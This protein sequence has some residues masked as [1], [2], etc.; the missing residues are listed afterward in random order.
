LDSGQWKTP[1]NHIGF[2]V[3]IVHS[4]KPSSSTASEAAKYNEMDLHSREGERMKFARPQGGTNPITDRTILPDDVIGEIIQ[5]NQAFIPIAVGP[6]GGFRSLFCHFIDDVN[7]L[8][9][10]SFPTDRP[11]T[12]YSSSYQTCNTPPYTM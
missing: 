10:P 5:S 7:T 11:N 12:R 3:T 4:T 2:D 1:Y 9:L 8:P 6:F